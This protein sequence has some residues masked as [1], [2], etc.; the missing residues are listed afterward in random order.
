MDAKGTSKKTCLLCEQI[1]QSN[2]PDFTR[3]R[4][5][6]KVKLFSVQRKIGDF[7]K[8]FYI[9]QIERSAYQR[10]YYKIFGEHHVA[11]VRHKSFESTPV[12]I[13]NQSH[14]ANDLALK[15]TFNYRMKYLITIIPYPWN[16]AV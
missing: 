12:N 14:Y 15:P 13:R 9:Q 11:D 7:H 10:S 16:V 1:I 8:D 5:Y 2:N 3:R 4:M 6:E